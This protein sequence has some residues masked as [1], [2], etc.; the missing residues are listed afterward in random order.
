MAETITTA[1]TPIQLWVFYSHVKSISFIFTDG[2][3]AEFIQGKYYTSDP[4]KVAALKREIKAGN[5]S[6]FIKPGE[7]TIM[8]DDLDPVTALKKKLRSELMQ[9]LI[10]Q[11]LIV[12]TAQ[13]PDS[14]K[15]EQGK[16]NV[17]STSDLAAI[18]AGGDGASMGI[19]L[20]QLKNQAS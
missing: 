14:G 19:R 20:A 3:K 2:N 7:E 13:S 1:D 9:E 12:A 18:S 10:D 16:L 11:G 15:S 5:K 17:Q 4:I 6:F 8:S